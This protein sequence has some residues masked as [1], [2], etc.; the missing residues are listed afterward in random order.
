MSL[1]ISFVGKSVTKGVK[2]ILGINFESIKIVGVGDKL[3]EGG[4]IVSKITGAT[5]GSAGLAKGSVDLAEALACQDGICAF[6]SGVG[7]A[8][9]S[10]QIVASFVP[11]PN[12]TAVITTPISIGCKVFVWCCK[13]SK[14]PWG[15]C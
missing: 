1:G 7:C 8:A 13:K 10:L 5:A 15:S 6:V 12:V 11:G 4:K 14:L 3:S 2:F 9:D